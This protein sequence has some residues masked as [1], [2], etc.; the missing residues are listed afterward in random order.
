MAAETGPMCPRRTE[1]PAYVLEQSPG[2]DTPVNGKCPFCGGLMGGDFMALVKLGATLGPTDKDYKVY[3]GDE[4]PE[5]FYFQHL[6]EAQQIE[7]VELL[8]GRELNIGYPGRFTRLPF[9]VSPA[10]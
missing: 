3:V 8:N 6:D 5:K 7:F 10:P 9:F 4:P 2:P 1:V